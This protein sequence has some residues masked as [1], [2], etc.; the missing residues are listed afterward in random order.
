MYFKA[1]RR[2]SVHSWLRLHTAAPSS[3]TL[4]FAIVWRLSDWFGWS[5]IN[6][7]QRKTGVSYRICASAS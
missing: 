5:K 3:Q 7:L 4:L 6:T 1:Y 2:S